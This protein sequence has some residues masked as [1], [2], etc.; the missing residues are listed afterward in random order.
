MFQML[1]FEQ[2][3]WGLVQISVIQPICIKVFLISSLL[4]TIWILSFCTFVVRYISV[5]RVLI[6]TDEG[7]RWPFPRGQSARGVKLTTHVLLVQR[8]RMNGTVP[9]PPQYVFKVWCLIKRRDKFTFTSWRW[10]FVHAALI[11]TSPWRWR[12]YGPPKR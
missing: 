8:S 3:L 9:P 6:D 1:S 2:K 11:F 4:I 12:Q 7:Y 10:C 5:K